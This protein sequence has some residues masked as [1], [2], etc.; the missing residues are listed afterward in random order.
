MADKPSTVQEAQARA[1]LA[2]AKRLGNEDQVR[3]AEKHLAAL[4]LTVERAA[5]ERKAAA[6]TSEEPEP[7]KAVPTARKTPREARGTTA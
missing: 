1:Q 2:N 5:K 4:G 7:E 6:E 3:A